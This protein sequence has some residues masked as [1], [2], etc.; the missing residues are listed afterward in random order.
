MGVLVPFTRPEKVSPEVRARLITIRLF[1][2][3]LDDNVSDEDVTRR[4]EIFKT[5][6]LQKLGNTATTSTMD[7]WGLYPSFYRALIE[8]I[9]SRA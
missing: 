6:N 2:N 3:S 4:R 5:W 8:E 7:E 9:N 1:L